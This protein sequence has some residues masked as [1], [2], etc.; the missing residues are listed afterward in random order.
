MI[1]ARKNVALVLLSGVLALTSGC[2]TLPQGGSQ[3]QDTIYATYRTVQ[4]LDRNLGGTVTK[5]NETS[6]DLAARLEAYDQQSR[7]LEGLVE[8]NQVRIAMVQT[9]VDELTSTLYRHFNLTPPSSMYQA[10]SQLAPGVDLNRE[11]VDVLPPSPGGATVTQPIGV[12]SA[13]SPVQEPLATASQVPTLPQST[14]A[15]ADAYNQARDS[16]LS[17]DYAL[18]QR[19]FSSYLQDFPSSE[20]SDNA[21]FWLA[22]SYIKL[23]QLEPA[24]DAFSKYVAMYP[25]GDRVALAMN[26]QAVALHKLGRVNEAI[27]IFESIVRD[28]PNDPAAEQARK[29]LQTLQKR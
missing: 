26:Q 9:K 23:E 16:Y 6:A 29:S 1:M 5:L 25:E 11:V 12:G 20:W 7:R 2:G 19:Q 4:N 28:Y 13:P 14:A 18:A 15:P 3:S 17:A 22:Q 10:P 21:L 24:V 8:E 27:A